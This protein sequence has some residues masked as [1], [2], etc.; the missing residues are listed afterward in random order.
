MDCSL[1]GSSVHGIFQARVLEWGAIAFSA[2]SLGNLENM[3]VMTRF[4]QQMAAGNF[5]ERMQDN[6]N[7]E[8]QLLLQ[9][10]PAEGKGLLAH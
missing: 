3:S 1:P 10:Q 9:C 2:A 8:V 6:P 7:W 5:G 4:G